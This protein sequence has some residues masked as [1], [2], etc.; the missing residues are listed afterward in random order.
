M[1]VVWVIEVAH[2]VYGAH[3]LE[4][5][6]IGVAEIIAGRRRFRLVLQLLDETARTVRTRI[7]LK[8]LNWRFVNNCD[9]K[10]DFIP[11]WQNDCFIA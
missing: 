1:H 7:V 6:H 2:F 5:A 10:T 8:F 4:V 3:V 11:E 9:M